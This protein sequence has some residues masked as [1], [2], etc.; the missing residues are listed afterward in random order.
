MP[1]MRIKKSQMRN[2]IL[3]SQKG[4]ALLL[5]LL[6]TAVLTTVVIE[7]NYNANINV[8][9]AQN[10]MNKMKAGY[11]AKSGIKFVKLYLES[12][13]ESF[14]GELVADVKP[15]LYGKPLPLG[16]GFVTIHMDGEEGRIN[17]NKIMVY[18]KVKNMF[19]NLLENF[20]IDYS[21]YV[22]LVD[23]IDTDD[24][25]FEGIGAESAYYET[26]P[27]PYPC[28]NGHLDSMDELRLVKGIDD[29]VFNTLKK[30]CTIYSNGLIN[31]NEA[32]KEVLLA[33]SS[34]LTEY[35][36]QEI[37][38]RREEAEITDINELEF[39]G[40]VFNEIKGALTLKNRY[41]RVSS[42]GTVEDIPYRIVSY[43]RVDSAATKLLYSKEE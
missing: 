7:Y 5:T 30:Y 2:N 14:M 33:L 36:V 23:W 29:E 13:V 35:D 39:L 19:L 43:M 27:E 40:D 16:D 8:D 10:Y 18:P 24:E 37:I 4:M 26:L 34:E 12:D 20:N 9:V 42:T 38:E 6:V 32:P 11:L 15:M 31:I 28:K 3:K 17:I 21:V 22:N 1:K 41:Y 25:P